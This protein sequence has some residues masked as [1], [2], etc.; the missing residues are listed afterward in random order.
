MA[1]APAAGSPVL[2]LTVDLAVVGSRYRDTRNGL[3]VRTSRRPGWP[4]AS[5]SGPPAPGPGTWPS[6]APLT[7]G[8]L[9][10]AV[11][12]ARS[13]RDFHRG[14]TPSSIRR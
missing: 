8:N 1:R 9:E 7:F 12:G 6:A 11:P 14:W 4:V 10:K 13:P 3:R 5:T 2:V